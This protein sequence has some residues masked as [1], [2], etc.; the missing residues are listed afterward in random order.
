MIAIFP[1]I[2]SCAL[3]GNIEKTAEVVRKYFGIFNP[4]SECLDVRSTMINAGIKVQ[5]HDLSPRCL[6]GVILGD[7]LKGCAQINCIVHEQLDELETRFILAHLFGH[8]IFDLQKKISSGHGFSCGF[9]LDTSPLVRFE[10]HHY[11][12]VFEEKQG[13]ELD[14]FAAALLIPKEILTAPSKINHSLQ[15]FAQ[16][17][18]VTEKCLQQR[19]DAINT[20]SVP[21]SK[22]VAIATAG[23]IETKSDHLQRGKALPRDRSPTKPRSNKN[24]PSESITQSQSRLRKDSTNE[25][26]KLKPKI[27]FHPSPNAGEQNAHN[28][29]ER[30]RRLADKIDKSLS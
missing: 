28:A 3:S 24:R 26:I 15:D 13:F 16:R 25:D 1:E 19:I 23:R 29:L 10:N 22:M 30:I 27:N 21:T 7:D 20:S 14:H 8:Y 17:F 11:K 5:E 2:L 18:A 9:A 6:K 4:K 12:D